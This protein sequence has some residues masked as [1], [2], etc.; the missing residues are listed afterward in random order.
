MKTSRNIIV[1][2]LAFAAIAFF[3]VNVQAK[4]MGKWTLLG[5]RVVDYT[6]DHDNITFENT[7]NEF[8][9]IR[10]KVKEGSVHVYKSTVHFANGEKQD[11]DLPK[12]LFY[13][14]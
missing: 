4:L 9:A 10:I 13:R 8:S 3:A 7:K 14:H 1:W 6:L 12:N 5:T 2:V 11:I